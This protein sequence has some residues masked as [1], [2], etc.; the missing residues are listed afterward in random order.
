MFPKALIDDY[1][2]QCI[3]NELSGERAKDFITLIS[4]FDRVQCSAE[5]H[6]CMSMVKDKLA[7]FG[8]DNTIIER[9]PCD[10]RRK[11][12]TWPT[13]LGWTIQNG[14][15]WMKSPQRMKLADYEEIPL[16]VVRGSQS[17]DATAELVYVGTGLEDKEYEGIDVRGKIVLAGGST[18]SMYAGH[19]QRQAVIKRGALGVVL[20]LDP[21]LDSRPNQGQLIP[22]Y[23]M[24]NSA[25]E[26]DDITFGFCISYNTAAMLKKL[27]R[28]E[29]VILHASLDGKNHEST[30]D[31]MTCTIPGQELPQ[32]EIWLVAHMDH[33]QPGA[34]DNA[35]GSAALLEI[36][37][38]LK[39]LIL[40]K[41]L[42]APKRT[43]RF[44]WPTE[45]QGMAPW[46]EK[47]KD[48]AQRAF[49]AINCDM[50]G[51]DFFKTKSSLEIIRTPSSQPHY[52]ND[53]VENFA[54]QA[55]HQKI[56]SLRGR[57]IPLNYRIVPYRGGSDHMFLNDSSVSIP[58]VMLGENDPFYHT[59]HDTPDNMDT[60]QLKRAMYIA[61][62][63]AW[64]I[65]N[66][67]SRESIELTNLSSTSSLQD[68]TNTG[69]NIISSLTKSPLTSLHSVYHEGLNQLKWKQEQALLSLNS[70]QEIDPE[71]QRE[72]QRQKSQ[73]QIKHIAHTYHQQIEETYQ[74]L[75]Q[76]NSCSPQ[77]PKLS[78]KEKQAQ[79]LIPSRS[80]S[81]QGPLSIDLNFA[82]KIN[83]APP[84]DM[85]FF[86]I[87]FEIVS[88]IDGKR[89]LLDIRNAVSAE[90]GPQPLEVIET[91]LRNLKK[92]GL[93]SF[94]E[95]KKELS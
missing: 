42:P 57:D 95:N 32:E 91:F 28:Q 92:E 71:N 4:R 20:Y 83:N 15:L 8:I 87:Q 17:A 26:N 40:R 53:V 90:F 67:A 93:V 16:S 54:D 31:Q 33:Y 5:T 85:G 25:E 2:R 69:Y 56:T 27:M 75:C 44:L 77:K 80:A 62:G 46:L 34:H 30:I 3:L 60:T 45:F 66:G 23:G 79:Q 64:Y 35:S 14:E 1:S 52:I 21:E 68:I 41:E 50:I 19:V 84:G 65:A 88:F 49:A 86:D 47:N 58:T 73:E 89:S 61:L 72:S 55:A 81:F 63:S 36:A 48:I 38:T 70:T 24:W 12:W 82:Y 7:H 43:I 51:S 10:G 37:R 78:E 6:Q 39:K 76:Q 11:Y 59:A 9:F 18:F 29:K 22:Y 94:K 74:E 13:Y